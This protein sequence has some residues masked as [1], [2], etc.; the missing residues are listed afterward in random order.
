MQAISGAYLT[1]GLFVRA[2]EL[3]RLDREADREPSTP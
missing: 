2:E 1:L 3:R